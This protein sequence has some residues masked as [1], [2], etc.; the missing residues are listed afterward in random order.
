MPKRDRND[1]RKLQIVE[2]QDNLRVVAYFENGDTLQDF[3]GFWYC[4]QLVG[5]N[6]V[7]WSSIGYNKTTVK[8]PNATEVHVYKYP[9]EGAAV[10]HANIR[11]VWPL[12]KG[13][14]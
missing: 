6:R 10:D 14:H 3:G 1:I 13:E 11:A 4:W 9:Q 12:E 8:K 7:V 5:D 2:N